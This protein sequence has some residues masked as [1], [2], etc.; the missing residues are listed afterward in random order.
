MTL[1][2]I[3]RNKIQQQGPIPFVTFMQDALYTP[4]LGYYCNATEKLGAAG[5]FVTAP[6]LTPLFGY[7]LANQCQEIL[8][9]L[10]EPILFEFGAGTGQLCV[11]ILTQLER[12]QSL[13][14]AYHILEVSGYL[15]QR[16][17]A[18]IQE[19]I[20][21]LAEK[22]TWC[23]RWPNQPFN[24]IV[25]A[26]EV[27]D[28]MPVHRFLQTET[29]LLE[30]HVAL[31]D[32]Q[33]LIEQWLPC[34]DERLIAHV[35]R[36][37][38]PSQSPYQSEANLFI[39]DW[40]RSCATMLQQGAVFILDYGFP[41]HEY[42]HNDRYQGTLMCHYRHQAHTNPFIHL[43]QQD[44]TAH[45][46]FTHVAEAAFNAGFHVAGYTHQASFL[47]ANGLLSLL[48]TI[49]DEREQIHHRQA[50]KQL[51]EP[52]EMGEL[53]KVMALTKHIEYPLCGFQWQD[54]RASL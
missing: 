33:A 6:E 49:G 39:D 27:L 29:G 19:K 5:D 34:R 8:S 53:F 1:P 15:Q 26:N 2:D 43:G 45:V 44:I 23:S 50:I 3:I 11:D 51:T 48:S 17:Q 16:Q 18:L 42:Y 38:P 37:L 9:T 32:N 22:V 36:V 52:H 7:T 28:A 24:G 21:H 20:P 54:K 35:A 31:Q 12:Q 4:N 14:K 46:E 40:F 10:P 30:S 13:P 41:R 47:L 25:I